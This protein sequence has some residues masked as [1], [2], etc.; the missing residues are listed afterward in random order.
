MKNIFQSFKIISLA[1][2]LSF[3][4]SYALAWT[5]PT[6]TPPAGNVSAPINVGYSTLT[7]SST[8]GILGTLT[9]SGGIGGGSGLVADSVTTNEIHF[10]DGTVSTTS[11][12]HGKKLFT[13]VGTSN[14]VV[15]SG[16]TKVWVTGA[17]GAGGGGGY[18]GSPAGG[19][20]SGGIGGISYSV[21][22]KEFSVVPLATYP[23]TVGFAGPGG[24]YNVDGGPGGPSSFGTLLVLPNGTGGK[25]GTTVV[26]GAASGTPG[27]TN[28]RSSF[29]NSQGG[30]NGWCSATTAFSG[31]DGA[32]GFVLI[33][34]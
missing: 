6:A 30:A 21:A 1:V 8:Q 18:I 33:E 16:V 9:I 13:T 19:C 15:P 27:G 10:L 11:I 25:K 2:V 23:I 20:R 3:G 34:W 5:A 17:G 31:T 32:Q 29:F 14:F 12:P 28:L 4:L 22:A 7:S 24:G 26:G